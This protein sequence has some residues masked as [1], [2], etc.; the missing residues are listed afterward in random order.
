MAAGWLGKD[1]GTRKGNFLSLFFKQ[2]KER[3]RESFFWGMY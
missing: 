1:G 2:K 3:I